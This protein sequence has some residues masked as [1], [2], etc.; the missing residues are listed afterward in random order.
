MART[1]NTRPRTEAPVAAD[2]AAG[3]ATSYDVGLRAGVSQSAASRCF[4]PG[5]SV[6]AK[7]RKRVMTAAR[8]LGYMPNAIA[9]S[10]I[11]RRTNLIAVMLSNLTN[12]YYPEVLSE[13][14]AHASARG[15]RILLFALPHESDIDLVMEQVLQ[16]QV[17]GMVAAV[18]LT[19][20]QLETFARRRTPVVFFNRYLQ[21]TPVN[22]V[23]CDQIDGARHL[24]ERLYK[25]GHRSFG[26]IAGPEDSVVGQ[27]RL[28]GS[29]D[30][31]SACGVRDVQV[32]NGNYDYESGAR[33]FH[34]LVKRMRRPPAAVICA[35]DVMAIGCMDAARF[36]FSLAIPAKLSVVGFDGDGPSRWS[37][38]QLTTIRQPVKR[39]A[40][41][42]VGLLMDR[43]ENPDLPPERRLL[44]GQLVEGHSARLG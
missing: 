7:M 24:V 21:T 9:R 33:G 32:V 43:I 26:I 28:K 1:Q 38:Y 23:C 34:E 8:E 37:S 18:R 11:T 36:D 2:G 25:A 5:A 30:N 13:L 39:M 27:E 16:Y 6:S 3:S 15:V 12:L 41:A 29:L 44:T 19:S 42:A 22:S 31:L 10:L 4:K 17:D 14:A 40:E 35:N 20:E